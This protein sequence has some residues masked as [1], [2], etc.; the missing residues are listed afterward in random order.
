M[1]A[2]TNIREKGIREIENRNNKADVCQEYSL[3]NFMI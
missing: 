1:A 3:I 2:A